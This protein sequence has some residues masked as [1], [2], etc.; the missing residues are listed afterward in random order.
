M[1]K[2]QDIKID[3]VLMNNACIMLFNE[4]F[5]KKEVKLKKDIYKNIIFVQHK[6][7]DCYSVFKLVKHAFGRSN[8]VNMHE[9]LFKDCKSPIVAVNDLIDKYVNK[10][11]MNISGE[12]KLAGKELV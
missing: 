7:L 10:T 6:H 9:A 5:G 8:C 3:R 1:L 2:E 12:F 11:C 4:F